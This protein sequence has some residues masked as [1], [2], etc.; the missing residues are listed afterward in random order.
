MQIE[1]I[2]Y[3]LRG[4][5]VMLDSDLADLYQVNTRDLNRQVKRHITRFPDDFLILPTSKEL[6]H[7][8]CQFGTANV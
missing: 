6:E 4:L 2:I 3:E 8:R 1:K 7:L 5:K